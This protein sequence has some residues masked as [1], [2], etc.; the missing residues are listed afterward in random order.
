MSVKIMRYKRDIEYGEARDWI[1]SDKGFLEEFNSIVKDEDLNPEKA[2]A[3]CSE[4]LVEIAA[5]YTKSQFFWN[6]MEYMVRKRIINSFKNVYY[7]KSG[8]NAIKN[9]AKYSIVNIAPNHRSVFDFM[10]LPYILVKETKFMPI[11]LA[12]DVFNTF[13]IGAVF[14][15][16]GT[17]FVRREESDKLY[18]LVFKYYVMMISRCRLIHM[19]F[20]E[21][22]RNKAGGYSE[23][24]KGILKYMLDGARRYTNSDVAFLPIG[25][26]YDYVPESSIVVEEAKSGKRKHILKSIASYAYKSDLGNCYIKFGK[27]IKFSEFNGKLK[28]KYNSVDKLGDRIMDSIKSLVIV[29]PTAL[30]CHTLI[31]SGSMD[32]KHFKRKF[33]SNYEK[34]KKYRCDVSHV[35]PNKLEHYLEFAARKGILNLHRTNKEIVISSRNSNI[36][37]YYNNNILH[38]FRKK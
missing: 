15:K 32:Y 29:S 25:I 36:V 38:L 14:R 21:G 3:K 17:Y 11:I 5:R 13:P 18:S 27:P 28:S 30:I 9:L 19:F 12:A 10:I 37:Q 23:P 8:V 4:Y 31:S 24:K 6:A 22:G 2:K 20:I 34:L 35:N 26:S 1:F 7:N 33:I 16:C